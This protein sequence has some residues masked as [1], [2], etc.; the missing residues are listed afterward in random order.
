MV[1]AKS[2]NELG[3]Q[4][5]NSYQN[6][7][8]H[9]SMYATGRKMEHFLAPHFCTDL[10]ILPEVRYQC[11]ITP[12]SILLASQQARLRVSRSLP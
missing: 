10:F 11:E 1:R 8:L 6:P 12:A 7:I 5:G 9:H 4:P 2:M 3:D